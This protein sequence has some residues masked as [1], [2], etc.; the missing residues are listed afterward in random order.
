MRTKITKGDYEI[1]FSGFANEDDMELHLHKVWKTGE[2]VYHNFTKL[3]ND[4]FEL[5]AG[6]CFENMEENR[7][8]FNQPSGND[9]EV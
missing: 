8:N 7:E 6:L 9:D 4:E 5:V 1:E 2:L 3:S